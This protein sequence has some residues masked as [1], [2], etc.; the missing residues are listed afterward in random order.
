MYGK[1]STSK[2]RDISLLPSGAHFRHLR[3]LLSSGRVKPVVYTTIFPLGDLAKG[4]DALAKR[5]TW[6]KVI[7]RIKA[8]ENVKGAKL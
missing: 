4:L 2:P 6:G 7:V 1:G 8:E 3:R 5:Q